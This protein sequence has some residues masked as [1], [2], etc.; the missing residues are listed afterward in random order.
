M[1]TPTRNG[2]NWFAYCSNDPI[3]QVDSSGKNPLL[4]GALAVL[5]GGLVAGLFR[6]LV[7]E[8]GVYQI[9]E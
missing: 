1:G 2:G 8:T 7:R 3:N 9:S 5:F 4:I 6:C